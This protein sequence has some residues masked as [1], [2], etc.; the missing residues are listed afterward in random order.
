MRIS[1]GSCLGLALRCLSGWPL[2]PMRYSWV[3]GRHQSKGNPRKLFYFRNGA[4][5]LLA[6]GF[7][8]TRFEGNTTLRR[9]INYVNTALLLAKSQVTPACSDLKVGSSH[10]RN[11]DDIPPMSHRHLS[12]G[13]VYRYLL[14]SSGCKPKTDGFP[15]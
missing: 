15:K 8:S 7:D 1:R 12:D 2:F 10:P 6:A 14:P 4:R 3:N 9:Q 11:R 5:A 13:I